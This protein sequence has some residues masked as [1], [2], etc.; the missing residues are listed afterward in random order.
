MFGNLFAGHDQ[1]YNDAAVAVDGSPKLGICAMGHTDADGGEAVAVE[2][3]TSVKL[4]V[5]QE[6]VLASQRVFESAEFD[7]DCEEE[8][9]GLGSG[10]R[11]VPG[12]ARGGARRETCDRPP[13]AEGGNGCERGGDTGASIGSRDATCIEIRGGANVAGD[14]R[15][16]EPSGGAAYALVAGAGLALK[17]PPPLETTGSASQQLSP[18][19]D[20]PA[21]F[22]GLSTSDKGFVPGEEG[23]SSSLK[24]MGVCVTET[25]RK[26]PENPLRS[27]SVSTKVTDDTV[28][29]I[30]TTKKGDWT[31][32]SGGLADFSGPDVVSGTAKRDGRLQTAGVAGAVKAAVAA[33]YAQ[34]GAGKGVTTHFGSLAIKTSSVIGDASLMNETLVGDR[35]KGGAGGKLW[36]WKHGRGIVAG[37]T[38]DEA[39]S[40]VR[41]VQSSPAWTSPDRS[42][43]TGSTGTGTGSVA[44]VVSSPTIM[45]PRDSSQAHIGCDGVRHP[46]S[47]GR[48][49]TTAGAAI[50]MLPSRGQAAS[51]VPTHK[52]GQKGEA[53]KTIVDLGVVHIGDRVAPSSSGSGLSS[54]K[55]LTMR[56]SGDSGDGGPVV[57]DKGYLGGAADEAAA[58]LAEETKAEAA[59]LSA[60]AAI[61]TTPG[62]TSLAKGTLRG[63]GA[64]GRGVG[65]SVIGF[66]TAGSLQSSA[67]TESFATTD[68]EGSEYDTETPT[69]RG[70]VASGGGGG[71][72]SSSGGGQKGMGLKKKSFQQKEPGFR[73]DNGGGGTVVVVPVATSGS[74]G[75]SVVGGPQTENNL[76]SESPL[77]KIRPSC[78]GS[79]LKTANENKSETGVKEEKST[80]QATLLPEDSEECCCNSSSKEGSA[81]EDT[82]AESPESWDEDG[83]DTSA[84]ER[85]GRGSGGRPKEDEKEEEES[86]VGVAKTRQA[87]P[88]ETEEMESEEDEKYNLTVSFFVQN[89]R[90][91]K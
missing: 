60:R 47:M 61:A 5:R 36:G 10:A 87:K 85:V 35:G 33:A 83:D 22:E 43:A 62:A 70:A 88:M 89:S 8:G 75:V 79:T 67:G 14:A 80:T 31:L 81:T 86:G 69:L 27:N 72:E 91:I 48:V 90:N 53:K 12:T 34:G 26:G 23:A 64:R 56:T 55:E 16:P 52:Q 84:G 24:R 45:S 25:S 21:D 74:T 76:S 17:M 2:R 4:P 20:M 63:N 58:R 37:L 59:A 7:N 65:G 71:S 51:A 3:P 9:S 28:A 41:G 82:T 57:K 42:V 46:R 66:S 78:S 1:A 50:A 32:V 38:A 6:I 40:S 29:A 49:G 44:G 15:R 13:L 77:G 30:T 19:D 68:F 54:A 39:S 73:L 11:A 18:I